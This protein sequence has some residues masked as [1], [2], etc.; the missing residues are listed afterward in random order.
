MLQSIF[1]INIDGVSDTSADFSAARQA[2]Q[3]QFQRGADTLYIHRVSGDDLSFRQWH[4]LLDRL[5]SA[6]AV[7]QLQLAAELAASLPIHRPHWQPCAKGLQIS[8]QAFYQIRE[9]WLAPALWPSMPLSYVAADCPGGRH[10]LRPHIGDGLL[11]EKYLPELQAVFSLR[12]AEVERDGELFH[13]WQND[14]RVAQFWEEAR[15]REELDQYLCDCRADP[16]SEPLIAYLDGVAFAYVQIYWA[17]EDRIAPYCDAD[18]FDLGLHLLVGEPRFLGS[19][20]T[21]AWLKAMTQCLFL[22]DPRTRRLVGEPRADNH[23][24]LRHLPQLGWEFVKEFDFPHKRAALVSCERERFF[25][26]IRL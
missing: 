25:R 9:V 24:L 22:L 13:R 17:K 23:R 21:G 2:W 6:T 19:K 5:C 11:F 26:E 1:K 10:P 12:R 7:E 3:I 16:H 8:R 14:P 20:R 18:D 4:Q 15:S